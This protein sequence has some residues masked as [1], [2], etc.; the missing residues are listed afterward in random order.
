MAD[1]NITVDVSTHASQ[2][3][4]KRLRD[5][6]ATL[7]L[8][9]Q[10][11]RAGLTKGRTRMR[12]DNERLAREAHTWSKAAEVYAADA[13]RYRWL[14]QRYNVLCRMHTA[15]G[16]GLNLR[17]VYVRSAEQFDGVIDAAMAQRPVL[18]G[19]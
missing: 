13:E 16:L 11:A 8:D 4:L 2:A 15:Q 3:E 10:Y 14:R 19:A 6:N 5:E 17:T 1:A 7:K 9:L 12:E 18:G